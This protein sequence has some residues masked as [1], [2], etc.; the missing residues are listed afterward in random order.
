MH[1]S[2]EKHIVQISI[3]T[4]QSIHMII[5]FL[6]FAI[7]TLTRCTVHTFHLFTENVPNKDNIF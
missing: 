2:S 1:L 3:L 5:S 7:R 4:C 6:L